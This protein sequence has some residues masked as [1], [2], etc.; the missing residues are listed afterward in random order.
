MVSVIITQGVNI[1]RRETAF[2]DGVKTSD[3]GSISH[4]LKPLYGRIIFGPSK[5]NNEG[6][7]W[8]GHRSV[9]SFIF[10]KQTSLDF[11]FHRDQF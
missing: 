1:S 11:Y 10:L 3:L 8:R 9:I 2:Y 5:K 7:L 6:N 4:V